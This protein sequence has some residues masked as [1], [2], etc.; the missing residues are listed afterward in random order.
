M[1]P[2]TVGLGHNGSKMNI[3]FLGTSEFAVPTLD[4][5]RESSH[6]LRLVVTAPD[7]PKGRGQK[8]ISSPVAARAVALELPL[9]QPGRINSPEAIER[10]R[11]AEPDL[12]VV[13]AYG[14]ILGRTVLGVASKAIVNLHG[15]I[16]PRWRGAAPIARAIEARD[17]ETGPSLQHVVKAVDAGDVID[18]E[19]MKI[20]PSETA[21]ELSA[22]M[23]RVAAR[24]LERNL[25]G[26]ESG[27][28]PRTRQ[29][30][31]LVTMA[32]MLEKSEGKITWTRPAEEVDAHI[33]A[34]TPWPGA[35]TSAPS[36]GGGT[37]RVM[38]RRAEVQETGA[39]TSL[40]GTVVRS[41]DGLEVQTGYGTLRVL[42]LLRAGRK[43]ADAA[44]FLRGFPIPV[45]ARLR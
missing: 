8:V 5:L 28:A 11:A 41:G 40:P 14:Q 44:S 26:L 34:M 18:T 25:E 42:R 3:V 1:S 30:E 19:R 2:V 12:I 31:R 4:M 13:V 32:P 7:R 35:F 23:S 22:R 17:R 43:E 9:F 29:N 39:P 16:L 33:R 10:L 45:G 21:G 27:T 20:E 36:E 37:E 24:L 38:I 6:D 15:S